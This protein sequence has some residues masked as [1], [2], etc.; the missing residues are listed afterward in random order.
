[1]LVSDS[2]IL[3]AV[4]AIT[5]PGWTSAPNTVTVP[6]CNVA[7]S[8]VFR[9]MADSIFDQYGNPASRLRS[10]QHIENCRLLLRIVMI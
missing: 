2:G 6:C 9:P 4:A 7:S 1:M 10:Y 8:A 5:L 3:H